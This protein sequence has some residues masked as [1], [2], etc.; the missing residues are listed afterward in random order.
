MLRTAWTPVERGRKWADLRVD[1]I[2]LLRANMAIMTPV[3]EE[4]DPEK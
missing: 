2:P 4:L 3:E 1:V